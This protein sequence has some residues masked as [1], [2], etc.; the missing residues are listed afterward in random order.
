MTPVIMKFHDLWPH[1]G[2]GIPSLISCTLCLASGHIFIL[3]NWSTAELH[4]P[5]RLH[6]IL[7][8]IIDFYLVGGE[9]S[10][11]D[12]PCDPPGPPMG[13]GSFVTTYSVREEEHCWGWAVSIKQQRY[14]QCIKG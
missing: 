9:K 1:E 12:W 11:W 7:D 2:P 4:F 5:K 8:R 13:E 6:L 3:K 10:H 14:D